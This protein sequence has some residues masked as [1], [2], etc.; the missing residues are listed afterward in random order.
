V[1]A[2]SHSLTAL[3]IAAAAS[4]AVLSHYVIDVVA[5]YLVPHASFDDVDA[6]G[7]RGVIGAIAIAAA[8]VLARRAFRLCCEAATDR[9]SQA[10]PVPNWWIGAFFAAATAAIACV[11]VPVMEIADA[12]WG[13]AAIDGL[14]DAFGGSVL[15]GIATTVVCASLVGSA[16]FAAVHWLLSRRDRIVAAMAATIRR[17]YAPSAT[18]QYLNRLGGIAVCQPRLVAIRNGKRAPPR[19][20]REFISHSSTS[21]LGDICIFSLRRAASLWATSTH[22]PVRP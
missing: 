20:A 6:H 15:L 7:S 2:L 8:F 9:D 18:P 19:D 17:M 21:S 22:L 10:T 14:D 5:D 11:A 12:R 3:L 16:L 1:R 4:A 13:G